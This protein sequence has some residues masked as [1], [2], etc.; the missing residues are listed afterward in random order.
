MTPDFDYTASGLFITLYPNN[1]QAEDRW[2]E[3]ESVFG[4]KIPVTAWASVRS[5]LRVAKYTVRKAK[6]ISHK[7]ML[8]ILNNDP[9]GIL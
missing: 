8:D 7:E 6:L 9:L 4:G 2:A 3:I 1:P 5:Q